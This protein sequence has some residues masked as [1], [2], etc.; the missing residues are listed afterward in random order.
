LA[1][2]LTSPTYQDRVIGLGIDIITVNTATINDLPIV[3]GAPETTVLPS[4][5][6]FIV[7][8]SGTTG[9]PKFTVLKHQN[10]NAFTRGLP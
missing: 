6:A 1:L 3:E 10:L 9:V 8:T 2:V 4:N 7:A 5:A